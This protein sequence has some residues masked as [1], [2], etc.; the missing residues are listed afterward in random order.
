[1]NLTLT[2]IIAA[3][4]GLHLVDYLVVLIYLGGGIWAGWYFSRQ[5]EHGDDHACDHEHH[6]DNTNTVA[7]ARWNF[8]KTQTTFQ[9]QSKQQF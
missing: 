9:T 8:H 3:F 4:S 2:P 6:H 7:T 5:Q 1:M